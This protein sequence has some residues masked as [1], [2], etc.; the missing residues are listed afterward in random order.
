[1][2]FPYTTVFVA[3][4]DVEDGLLVPFY[5]HLLQ[6]EPS[7]YM[8]NVYAEFQLTGLRLG[9]FKPKES[10]QAEFD[11]G[12]SGSMSLCFEVKDLES[13]IDRLAVIGYPVTH[14]IT[15]ASHG[16]EVYAYDPAGNRLILHEAA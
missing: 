11:R 8:P 13:A 6:Q 1:M 14:N 9:I 12:S 7:I 4:A 3:L 10:H 15:I 2:S 5:Q 16:R